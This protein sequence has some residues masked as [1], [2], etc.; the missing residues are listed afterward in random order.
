MS[1]VIHHESSFGFQTISDEIIAIYQNIWRSCFI[2]VLTADAFTQTLSLRHRHRIRTLDLPE[3]PSP[4]ARCCWEFTSQWTPSPRSGGACPPKNKN[5]TTKILSSMPLHQWTVQ[6]PHHGP[7]PFAPR[8]QTSCPLLTS[9]PARSLLSLVTRCPSDAAHGRGQLNSH[10]SPQVR[11]LV[12]H[13]RCDSHSLSDQRLRTFKMTIIIISTGTHLLWA[14][15]SSPCCS[16]AVGY[17]ESPLA[18][19]HVLIFMLFKWINIHIYSYLLYLILG[20]I[21]WKCNWLVTLFKM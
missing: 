21:L 12:G 20:K 1:D 2:S 13:H 17:H 7:L 16:S 10:C 18:F 11:S 14:A 3:G 19:F 9:Q 8:S 5:K 6:Q 15:T 4:A